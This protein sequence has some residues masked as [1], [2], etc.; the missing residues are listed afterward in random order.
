MIDSL[1]EIGYEGDITFEALS[2]VRPFP[3]ELIP[4]ALRLMA[5][6]GHYFKNQIEA[7]KDS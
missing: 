2:F 3:D 7:K 5:D 4:S 6:V 1:A